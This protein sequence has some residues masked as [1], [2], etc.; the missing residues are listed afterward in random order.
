M[1]SFDLVIMQYT[2]IPTLEGRTDPNIRVLILNG[3]KHEHIPMYLSIAL[4]ESCLQEK[5]C[6]TAS[7]KQCRLSHLNEVTRLSIHLFTIQLSPLPGWLKI[8][9]VGSSWPVPSV[10]FQNGPLHRNSWIIQA[11]PPCEHPPQIL[12]ACWAI[13]PM[14]VCL[15]QYDATATPSEPQLY[16][17]TAYIPFSSS[18]TIIEW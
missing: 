8:D 10:N 16:L 18:T 2:L 5:V 13:V 11:L 9:G 3:A 15:G 14:G 7:H 6:G 1:T 4:S 12:G 17:R